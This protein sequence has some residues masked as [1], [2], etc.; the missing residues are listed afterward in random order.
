[1]RYTVCYVRWFIGFNPWWLLVS[2]NQ[3]IILQAEHH[4]PL[5][6]RYRWPWEPKRS[7]C[8]FVASTSD[9]LLLQAPGLKKTTHNYQTK[10]P[11]RNFRISPLFFL[12]ATTSDYVCY[13]KHSLR[14]GPR[15]P[16]KILPSC[17]VG[18]ISSV[19]ICA[20]NCNAACC[21]INLLFFFVPDWSFLNA[22]YAKKQAFS[23]IWLSFK[24]IY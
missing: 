13:V 11:K 15:H 24:V 21:V 4:R 16:L 18:S 9:H 14:P 2:C 6:R 7:K 22:K 8:E 17:S 12:K 10:H 20:S 23:K 19:T 3:S 5:W 1:M